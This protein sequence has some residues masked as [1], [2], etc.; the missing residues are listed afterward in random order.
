MTSKS[1]SNVSALLTFQP[2]IPQNALL[3][4]LA[5]PNGAKLSSRSKRRLLAANASWFFKIIGF[6][7]LIVIVSL[8]V[9]VTAKPAG[10][11]E[12]YIIAGI[13]LIIGAP[14]WAI[15]TML[16]AFESAPGSTPQE[17]ASCFY[18]ELLCNLF[19]NYGKA[20]SMLAPPV[21]EASEKNAIAQLSA[22]WNKVKELIK[23]A[24]SKA[25]QVKTRCHNCDEPRTGMWTQESWHLQDELLR[26]RDAVRCHSC[27]AIYCKKCFVRLFDRRQCLKCNT[28]LEHEALEVFIA[29]PE[30]RVSFE[31]ES[32]NLIGASAEGVVEIAAHLRT[33]STYSPPWPTSDSQNRSP[34]WSGF[35]KC[36]FHNSAVRIGER[37][38]LLSGEPG[39]LLNANFL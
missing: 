23:A 28:A 29:D 8:L 12:E 21:L 3:A 11:N 39:A 4:A 35:L 38:F 14:V 27:G 32:I 2:D 15:W 17:S 9:I 13:L 31:L 33:S 10:G 30:I 26:E 6:T 5:A 22:E 18:S 1:C 20:F 24:V 7:T 34:N 25:V 19:G 16:K 36:V 37:W